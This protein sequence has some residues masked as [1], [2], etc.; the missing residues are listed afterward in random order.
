V[1]NIADKLLG[2]Q[3]SKPVGKYL[4]KRFVTRLEKLKIGFN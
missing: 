1:L 2:V 3:V 4:T